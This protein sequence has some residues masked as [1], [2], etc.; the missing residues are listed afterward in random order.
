MKFEPSDFEITDTDKSVQVW[1][2]NLV[3]CRWEKINP[4]AEILIT[5]GTN[6]TCSSM[7][8]GQ[9]LEYCK[10]EGYEVV[11]NQT[12]GEYRGHVSR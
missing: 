3:V 2:G 7:I 11:N 9:A 12:I 10:N 8:Y 4:G 1:L 6:R 5:N